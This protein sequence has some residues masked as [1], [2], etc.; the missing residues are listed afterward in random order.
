MNKQHKQSLE[1]NSPAP[2]SILP[3]IYY[4]SWESYE[5][6]VQHGPTLK[7]PYGIRGKD[8]CLVRFDGAYW[9]IYM[10]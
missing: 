4:A 2:A 10:S 9:S 3:G 5:I 7:A 8:E 6:A 1:I